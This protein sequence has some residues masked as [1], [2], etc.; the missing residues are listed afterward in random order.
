MRT[1]LTIVLLSVVFN[2]TQ[3]VRAADSEPKEAGAW[4]VG[5]PMVTYWAGPAM[6]DAV[7]RQMAEGGFNVVWCTEAELDVAGRHGLRA[8]LHHGLLSPGVLE[9]PAKR[10]QLDALIARVRRHPALYCY[11]ITDEPSAG[12]FPALGKL[13]A[14]LRQRDPA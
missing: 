4:E 3:P 13:V 12:A 14:Y 11:Y 2:I 6:T 7:A 10:E 8:Q 9:D 5:T 1:A